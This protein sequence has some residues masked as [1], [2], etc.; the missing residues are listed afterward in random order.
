M[1]IK[2]SAAVVFL[3]IFAFGSLA[4]TPNSPSAPALNQMPAMQLTMLRAAL[5]QRFS[6]MDQDG[7]GRLSEAEFDAVM[8]RR[9]GA[10]QSGDRPRNPARAGRMPLAGAGQDFSEIDTNDDGYVTSEEMIALVDELAK[11]DT[12]KDQALDFDEMRAMRQAQAGNEGSAEP[13]NE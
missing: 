4:Q 11:F 13:A 3:S 12:N 9:Q 5:E 1:T 10:N 6:R 2:T 8:S 7:D